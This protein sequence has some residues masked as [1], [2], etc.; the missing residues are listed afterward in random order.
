MSVHFNIKRN[1][2]NNVLLKVKLDFNILGIYLINPFN[3][4]RIQSLFTPTTTYSGYKKLRLIEN[5]GKNTHSRHPE[6][7]SP[8]D[9]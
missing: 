6:L 9:L 5:L 2:S 8:L 4:Y 7:R 3:C 1:I